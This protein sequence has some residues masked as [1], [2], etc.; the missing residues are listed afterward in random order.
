MHHCP[1]NAAGQEREQGEMAKATA[2]RSKIMLPGESID[3]EFAFDKIQASHVGVEPRRLAE[4][5]FLQ[6]LSDSLRWGRVLIALILFDCG[7]SLSNRVCRHNGSI[8]RYRRGTEGRDDLP[9]GLLS[10]VPRRVTSSSR[11]KGFPTETERTP[12]YDD[13]RQQVRQSG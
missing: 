13:A 2:E 8:E 10:I 1:A 4:P 5:A 11:P 6:E 12:P 3:R 9:R 7:D